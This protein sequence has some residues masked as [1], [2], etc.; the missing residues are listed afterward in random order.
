MSGSAHIVSACW[1]PTFEWLQPSIHASKIPEF[2]VIVMR[3]RSNSC[4]RRIESNGGGDLIMVLQSQLMRNRELRGFLIIPITVSLPLIVV[5][6]VF[7]FR[8]LG[9]S[10]PWNGIGRNRHLPNGRTCNRTR[11]DIKPRWWRE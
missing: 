9:F 2:A 5:V 4:A 1:L 11:W 7:R 3:A 8:T 10:V 6:F